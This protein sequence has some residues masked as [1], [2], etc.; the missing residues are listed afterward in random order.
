MFWDFIEFG[1]KKNEALHL[2]HYTSILHF[3]YFII[4]V[5]IIDGF[6]CVCVCFVCYF[7]I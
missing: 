3:F 4:F 1:K 5:Y 7:K 2:H 6:F